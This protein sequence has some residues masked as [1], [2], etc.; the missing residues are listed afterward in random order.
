MKE[1]TQREREASSNYLNRDLSWIEF[2]WRVLEEAQDADTPLLERM[3][4]LSIVSSNLD[5]FM[6]VR[7]AGIKDQI[8][9]GYLKKDFTG[10]TP[11]GLFKRVMKRSA[12]M[13]AEQYKTYRDISRQLAKEGIMFT[14]YEDLN[15]TQ[16]KA[17]D[18]YY[19]EIIFPV[20][21]P[22][23]VDQ[24]RPFPLVHT[25]ALYLAV[26]LMKEGKTPRVSR[27]LP[28]FRFRRICLAALRCPSA[29]TARSMSSSC[30]KI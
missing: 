12:K 30:W 26:V 14:D 21:T 20:L 24:S 27:I 7:V 6:S 18:E 22:M 29:P 17:M 19:H 9:A 28:L 5:E 15:L 1:M 3:K 2:N 13:V 11:A 4:F 10:Y 8:K 23:A 25:Q 16:R